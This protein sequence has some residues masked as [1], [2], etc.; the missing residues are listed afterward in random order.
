MLVA[1]IGSG[2]SGV[3][4]VV[5]FGILL[6]QRGQVSSNATVLKKTAKAAETGKLPGKVE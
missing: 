5:Q 1:A 2:I 3:I 4:L 6:W